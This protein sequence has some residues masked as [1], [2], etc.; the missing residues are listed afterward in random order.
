MNVDQSR[1]Q[2]VDRG[3]L[4]LRQRDPSVTTSVTSSFAATDAN[5][6]RWID[7]VDF[8]TL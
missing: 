8:P 5:V 1:W 6:A 2:L 4:S 7:G 3:A